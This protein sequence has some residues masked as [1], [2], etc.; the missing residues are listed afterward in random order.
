LRVSIQHLL[1]LLKAMRRVLS[2]ICGNLL[3]FLSM[4]TTVQ[5]SVT[6]CTV[7]AY[8]PTSPICSWL[9]R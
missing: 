6:S 9:S 5:P 3:F 2:L 8:K 4:Y 1:Y 7:S